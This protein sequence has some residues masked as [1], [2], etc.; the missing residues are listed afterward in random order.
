MFHLTD[1]IL[2]WIPFGLIAY[3]WMI[4]P[5][6]LILVVRLRRSVHLGRESESPQELPR[7]TIAVAAWNEE[8]CI[9]EKIRNCLAFDYPPDR[10]EILIGTDAV[11]DRTNDV[12][13]TFSDRRVRL[14][15]TDQRLGKSEVLNRL[16]PLAAGDL[17]LFTDADVLMSPAALRMAVRRFRDERVGV[18]LF[19][20]ERR[21]EEGHVAEGLWDWYENWLKRL[22][23][24]LGAAVGVYGWAMMLRRSLCRPIPPETINDDWV[25]GT[26][27]FRW[28]YAAVYEPRAT[29]WTKA[30]KARVEF[31]R[32]TRISRGNIQAFFMMPDLFLPKFGVKSWVLISHKLLRWVTPV[33]LL[34]ML[35]GSALSWQVPFFRVVLLLQMAVLLTT[36]LVLVAR[37]LARRLL[38]MQYYVWTNLA[39]V[40]GYW[41]YFF[42][43]R[44]VYNWLRT[45]RN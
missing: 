12:V 14:W 27:P 40:V 36:P 26:R 28:G 20:Y 2:F 4:F 9:G 29:S 44:L 10:L 1:I 31:T 35:V 33:L 7:V 22:E 37:G 18:L 41:Q 38:L 42:G 19:H 24:E 30:E 11:T 16:M 43:R 8:K 6:L 21:N 13:R 15:T 39:M 23:G 17:V 3:N 5:V 32:K 34:A 45:T 25:L